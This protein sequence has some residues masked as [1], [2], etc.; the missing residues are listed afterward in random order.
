AR[1]LIGPG[2][3][4]LSHRSSTNRLSDV[5]GH[6]R[7]LH[8]HA[9]ASAAVAECHG[10]HADLRLASVPDVASP[11][12]YRVGR[13]RPDRY[14]RHEDAGNSKNPFSSPAA[15]AS[16]SHDPSQQQSPNKIHPMLYQTRTY[17]PKPHTA[18]QVNQPSHQA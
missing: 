9:D 18:A 17:D 4:R 15:E 8:C 11:S 5:Q 3:A 6:P 10:G 2:L 12:C 1:T 7:V 16:T 13:Y 14:A